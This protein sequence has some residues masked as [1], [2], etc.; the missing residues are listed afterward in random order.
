MISHQS[1]ELSKFNQ[2]VVAEFWLKTEGKACKIIKFEFWLICVVASI[3]QNQWKEKDLNRIQ[4]LFVA[5]SLN[6]FHQIWFSFEWFSFK[7]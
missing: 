5:E 7:A 6:S 3:K 4:N 2:N 1:F